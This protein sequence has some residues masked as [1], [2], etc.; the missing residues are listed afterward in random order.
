[1]RFWLSFSA[2]VVGAALLVSAALAR[3]EAGSA[4][5]IFHANIAETDINYLDPA[6]N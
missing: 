2:C 4:S 1:M 3:P 5:K 6:L